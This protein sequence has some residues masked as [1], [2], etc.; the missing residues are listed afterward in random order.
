MVCLFKLYLYEIVLR[1][2]LNR[3]IHYKNSSKMKD[4]NEEYFF[5]DWDGIISHPQLDLGDDQD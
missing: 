1:F 5:L 3:Q 2:I 4:Y